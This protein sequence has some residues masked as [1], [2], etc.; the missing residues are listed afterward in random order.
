[1]GTNPIDLWAK[2]L[3]KAARE[4]LDGRRVEEVECI[5]GD[6]AGIARGKVMPAANSSKPRARSFRFRY[7]T[8]PSPANIPTMTPK[9]AGPSGTWF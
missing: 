6:F 2:Q 1:M 3:P 8:R 7:S 4:W 9:K 5:I